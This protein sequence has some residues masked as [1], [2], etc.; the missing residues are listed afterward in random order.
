MYIN[1]FTQFDDAML[2]LKRNKGR[3]LF[4]IVQVSGGI[5]MLLS[6]IMTILLSFVKDTN[7]FGVKVK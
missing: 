1:S 2:D 3:R 7:V 5:Y 6:F 4:F